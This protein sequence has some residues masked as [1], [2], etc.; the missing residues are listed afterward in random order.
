MVPLVGTHVGG[1]MS[2]SGIA[3]FQAVLYAMNLCRLGRD[4]ILMLGW[5]FIWNGNVKSLSETELARHRAPHLG[6]RRVAVTR[7]SLH[8]SDVTD[9]DISSVLSIVLQMIMLVRP[10]RRPMLHRNLKLLLLLLLEKGQHK[11]HNPEWLRCNKVHRRRLVPSKRVLRPRLPLCPPPLLLLVRPMDQRRIS[12]CRLTKLTVLC[13][14]LPLP[15]LS[16]RLRPRPQPR[17]TNQLSWTH[18]PLY[19]HLYSP[20]HNN[21]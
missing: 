18:Y 4:R 9:V 16:L 13:S 5:M 1:M 8:P 15:L 19:H 12:S 10:R 17:L 11:R 21:L 2:R 20:W 3:L 7:F 6:V 14:F